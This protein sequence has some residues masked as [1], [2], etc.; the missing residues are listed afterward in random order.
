M[1]GFRFMK[2]VVVSL[3]TFGVVCPQT[4]LLAEGSQAAIRSSAK[5]SEGKAT[6]DSLY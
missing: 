5:A 3:A 6:A 2:G 4:Q 1:N